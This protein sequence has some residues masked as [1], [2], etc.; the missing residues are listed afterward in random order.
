MVPEVALTEV[1]PTPTAVSRPAALMVTMLVLPVVHVTCVVTLPWVS[2]EK[3]AVAVYCWVCPVT[4]VWLVGETAMELMTRVLTVSWVVAVSA[5]DLAVMVVVPRATPVAR[6]ALLMV[7]T[8]VL[9]ELQAAVLVTSLVVPSASVAFAVY[10]SVLLGVMAALTGVRVSATTVPG[11]RKKSP[12]PTAA[13]NNATAMIRLVACWRMGTKILTAS[14]APLL[15]ED[16][17]SGKVFFFSQVTMRKPSRLF[18]RWFALV[19]MLAGAAGAQLPTKPRSSQPAHT[20]PARTAAVVAAPEVCAECI[21]AEET[22]LANDALRGRGS[23]THDEELAAHYLGS[24]LLRYGIAPAGDNGSYVQMATIVTRVAAAP[25][26]LSFAAAGSETR[27]T[28]GHE[29]IVLGLPAEKVSGPLQRLPGANAPVQKGAIVLVDPK[30]GFNAATQALQQGAAMALL[31][32]PSRFAQTWE[33]RGQRLPRLGDAAMGAGN[34]VVLNQAAAT[35]L[36]ALPE[37]TTITVEAPAGPEQ[38]SYTWNTVGI[39]RGS[40]PRLVQQAILLSAHL[41]HLGVGPPVN[42]DDIYNGADDDASGCVA[43]LQL[44]RA[45]GAAATPKRTVVFALF[46]SEEKGGL[47]SRWFLDHA[48]VPLEHF[49]ANLEFEMIGRPDP[50]VQ[51]DELWLA[52]WELSNLGPVLV[53]HGAKLVADQRPEQKFFQRSDNIAL[54]RRGV[55]AQSVSSFG[56]H[57][58]YHRPSDDLAHLDFAHLTAAIGSMIAPVRWLANSDFVPQWEPGKKP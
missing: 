51:P 26:V 17:K 5:P 21:R 27:W 15:Y 9:E 18:T 52:G 23:G 6:P 28:H 14:R 19:M 2:S 36:A 30:D 38:K 58:D 34:V 12:H 29:V 39:L 20:T 48:P 56:L 40:D 54:A 44:A 57:P 41:D 3:V 11:E 25:P 49:V 22:F 13:V 32:A 55:V 43:V 33:A 8:P 31:L 45:L 37:G 10:C 16:G 50:K 46:G 7:A 4:R 53:Q 42:G 47:G 24:E 1:V 35:A